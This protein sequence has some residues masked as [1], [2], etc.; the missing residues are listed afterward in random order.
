MELPIR[1]SYDPGWRYI[2]FFVAVGIVALALSAADYVPAWM[3]VLAGVLLIPSACLLAFRRIVF[4]R[5]LELRVDS[6]ILPTGFLRLRTVEIPYSD[7]SRVSECFLPLTAV[8]R[9][10]TP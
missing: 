4:R 3:G 8:T 1:Y 5:F 6:L 10:A 9:I 7:I 2:V